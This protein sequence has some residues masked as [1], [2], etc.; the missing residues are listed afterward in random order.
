MKPPP[1]RFC[2]HCGGKL[3]T[4]TVRTGE[5]IYFFER[6]TDPAGN[7]HVVHKCCAKTL[8]LRR[9]TAQPVGAFFGTVAGRVTTERDLKT[10]KLE[11]VSYVAEMAST[12]GCFRRIPTCK[13]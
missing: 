1:Q 10:G 2:W 5:R 4:K 12:P 8:N 9:I 7:E 6:W 11:R 13:D 3:G